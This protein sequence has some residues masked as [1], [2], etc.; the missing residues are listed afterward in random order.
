MKALVSGQKGSKMGL[1]VIT[2]IIHFNHQAQE[3][4]ESVLL[5]LVLRQFENVQTF[6]VHTDRTE[7]GSVP[8]PIDLMNNSLSV[9]IDPTCILIA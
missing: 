4:I 1:L 7:R 6:T 2:G 8:A 3:T 5:S 9:F